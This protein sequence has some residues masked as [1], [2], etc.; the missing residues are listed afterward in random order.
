MMPG[1]TINL[2][3]IAARAAVLAG[4]WWLIVQGQPEAWLVGLPAVA[5][6]TFASVHLGS[7]AWPQLAIAGLP[8]FVVLFLRESVLGGIDVARRTL[9]PTLRIRPGFRS[10]HLQLR[11]PRAR[12]LLVNCISLLPG[13]LAADC[14]GDQVELHLLD[15]EENPDAGIRRLE[16]AIARLYR[17]PLESADV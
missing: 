11:D 6:A 15:A 2:A 1:G 12:I 16:R 7:V 17:L 8:G 4:L 3:G 14:Q 10:Y 13:T 9:A 5:F